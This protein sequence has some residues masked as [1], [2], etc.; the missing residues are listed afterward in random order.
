MSRFIDDAIASLRPLSQWC[1][2]G[3]NPADVVWLDDTVPPTTDE[4]ISEAA[5]LEAVFNAQKPIAA[6]K[7]LRSVD[8]ENIK[9]TISSGKTFDGNEASQGRMSRRIVIMGDSDTVVWVL[10]DNTRS[11][12]TKDELRE[13]LALSVRE[14]DLLWVRPYTQLRY[15]LTNLSQ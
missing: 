15:S 5:R 13:A 10:A 6:A 14:Q 3:E 2:N 9:V 1:L 8:V 12:V 7:K 11:E 4:I